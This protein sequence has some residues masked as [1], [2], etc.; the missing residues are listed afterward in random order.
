MGNIEIK[1]ILTKRQLGYYLTKELTRF[2]ACEALDLLLRI[3]GK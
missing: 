3:E 1:Y 2:K